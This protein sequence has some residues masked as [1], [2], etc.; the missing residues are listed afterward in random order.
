MKAKMVGDVHYIFPGTELG[1]TE[2]PHIYKK[3]GYYYLMTAEGGTGYWHAMTICR[4][5][6]IFGPYEVHPQ[7]PIISSKNSPSNYLQ[8]TGHGDFVETQNGEWYAVYLT[9]R[10]ITERGCCTLGRETGIEKIEWKEDGWPYLACGGNVA[11]A[12]VEAPALPEHPWPEE[13]SKLTFDTEELDIQ[14]QSLRLPMTE[15]WCSL[16]A[17][18]GYLRLRGRESLGSTFEQSL[19]ARR[20]QAHHILTETCVEFDPNNFQQMAGLVAYY[21][22]YHYHY[23][24]IHGDDYWGDKSKKFIN[25]LTCNKYS[26]EEPI[27]CIEITDAK[28][29]YMR[30]DFNGAALQ[31]WYKLD[32]SDWKKIGPVLDGSILSDDY[33]DNIDVMYR[34]CF[35]GAF[36]GMCCQDLTSQEKVADFE[37]FEYQEVESQ[38]R[39]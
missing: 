17:R 36:V 4:S 10:P 3:D 38:E 9:S 29:V 19:V 7:N 13:P 8:K 6:S 30:C 24:H 23:L 18:K 32:E 2:G 22:T 5:K 33:V 27:E 12:K 37:Y 1:C 34:A 28:K 31:F 21:N 15:D 14:F 26:A 20:I 11:R 16:K 35:T 25:I 39:C